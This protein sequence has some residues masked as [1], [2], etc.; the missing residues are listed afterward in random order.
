[1]QSARV[2]AT[3]SRLRVDAATAEVLQTSEAAG[4]RAVLLKGP[5]LAA[6]YA[7]DPTHA[8]LNCDLWVGPADFEDAG[9]ALTG[10][11]FRAVIDDR[12]FPASWEEHASA[13]LRDQDGVVVD[14]HRRLQ[15]LG[16]DDE[17]AWHALSG[18]TDTITVAGHPV[19]V[20]CHPASVLYVTLHACHHGKQWGKALSH[21]ER[22]LR[23][24]EEQDWKRAESLAEQL[25]ATDAFATG[26][27]LV[28]Q[29]AELAAR[30][31][32]PPTQSVEVAL[33]A[34]TPPPIALGV[35]Q[36]ASAASWQQRMAIIARKTVPPPGFVRHWWPA[37]ARN[38]RMLALAYLYRPLWLLRH[39]PRGLRA[40]LT[41]TRKIR[42]ER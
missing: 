41:A 35:E 23:V 40:W 11:G 21:L 4:V 39:A 26:L 18:A 37:A 16:V 19:P 10:L 13:W 5:A 42:A 33:H 36:L 6:W 28:P 15:G 30:L 14:L 29:G 25:E 7:D 27:R 38:R 2:A 12:G 34:S 31:S 9:E 1:M 20:L 3:A 17:T 8:Y 32:L 22:A 24:A